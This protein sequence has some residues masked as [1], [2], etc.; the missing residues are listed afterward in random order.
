LA[1][2]RIDLPEEIGGCARIR[3]LDPLIKISG[4]S[5]SAHNTASR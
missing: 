1:R 2:F 5:V 4:I 3:T